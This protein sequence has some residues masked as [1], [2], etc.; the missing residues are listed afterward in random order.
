[1]TKQIDFERYSS[2]HIGPSLHVEIIDKIISINKDTFMVGGANNILVSPTPPKMAMLGKAFNFLRANNGLLHI[3]GAVSSAKILLYAKKHNIKNFELMQKLPGTL[4]GMIKMNAG[5]K[6]WEIFNHLVAIKTEFG[7]VKKKDIEFG[8]R[9][10][11]IKGVIYEATFEIERGFDNK[12]L[13]MFK[14]LRESQPKQASAGSCFKNP[15]NNF[16]GKLLDEVGLKGYRIGDVAFSHTH[17]NFLINLGAGTFEDAIELI[18]LAK[19]EVF[20]YHKIQLE[21]EIKIV[22]KS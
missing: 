16:A 1:M 4:G 10:T 2:I 12:L 19:R 22:T 8:Y 6:E 14:K 17:A 13:E 5:L 9:H 15:P 11:D 18:D 21:L 7:W 20:S 3:G